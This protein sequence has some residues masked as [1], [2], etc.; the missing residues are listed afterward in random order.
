MLIIGI[1]H[2]GDGKDNSII[3]SSM[4]SLLAYVQVKRLSQEN[5]EMFE[6]QEKARR[7]HEELTQSETKSADFEAKVNMYKHVFS[8]HI[9]ILVPSK[10]RSKI[11]R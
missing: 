8:Q 7:L 4:M 3:T 9:L 6:V 10:S 2:F 5:E 1:P 11:T